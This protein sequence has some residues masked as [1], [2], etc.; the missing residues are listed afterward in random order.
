MADFDTILL[1]S[2]LVAFS[3][4]VLLFQ[5]SEGIRPTLSE[6]ELFNQMPDGVELAAAAASV[7]SKG[8]MAPKLGSNGEV[9][10]V[11]H[12]F[13]P[14]DIV[15]VCDGEL[16]NL[17]GRV[18]SAEPDGRIIV[19]PSHNDLKEPIPFNTHELR[20]YFEQGDHVKVSRLRFIIFSSKINLANLFVLTL[21]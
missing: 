19:Q 10:S 13:L 18:T 17:R 3:I 2:I 6:L 11:D 20:K 5:I 9:L 15:E 12:G 16:K 7:A 4:L 21:L 14:G 8:S 1:K